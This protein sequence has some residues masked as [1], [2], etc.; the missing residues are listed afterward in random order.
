MFITEQPNVA[1]SV[2]CFVQ[3]TTEQLNDD[4]RWTASLARGEVISRKIIS[5]PSWDIGPVRLAPRALVPATSSVDKKASTPPLGVA[6]RCGDVHLL[7]S[8]CRDLRWLIA[9]RSP[10][11]KR[12][13]PAASNKWT[14]TDGLLLPIQMFYTVF[15][16]AYN[17]KFACTIILIQ[18][19]LI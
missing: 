4:N 6:A 10:V 17:W 14:I 8:K 19:S 11:Y 15:C 5:T 18:F 3:T 1:D 9:R 16:L 7:E 12:K 13:S 2:T